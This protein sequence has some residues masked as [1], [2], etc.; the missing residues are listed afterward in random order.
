MVSESLVRGNVV[1]LVYPASFSLS[2]GYWASSKSVHSAG[3]TPCPALRPDHLQYQ[4]FQAAVTGSG[5]GPVGFH[6]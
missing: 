3:V 5:V 2:P 6:L 4:F 1:G